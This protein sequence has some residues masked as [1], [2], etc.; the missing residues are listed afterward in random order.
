MLLRITKGNLIKRLAEYNPTKV[1]PTLTS[2][3]TDISVLFVKA[4]KAEKLQSCQNNKDRQK[5]Q[6]IVIENLSI[7]R[8]MNNA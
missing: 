3:V 7:R 2:Q 6:Y 1:Y 8:C 4:M 5:S